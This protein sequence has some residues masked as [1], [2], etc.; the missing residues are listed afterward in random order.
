MIAS[1]KLV[2]RSVVGLLKLY[3]H[4]HAVALPADLYPSGKVEVRGA[5][6]LWL[7]R[8]GTYDVR[9]GCKRGRVNVSLMR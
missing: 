8:K 9:D 2:E 1:R 3:R 7:G 5:G 6:I 4:G